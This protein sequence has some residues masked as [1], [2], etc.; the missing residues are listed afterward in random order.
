MN[1]KHAEIQDLP[2]NDVLLE[3]DQTI[4]SHHKNENK[5]D[6]DMSNVDSL[7]E[8]YDKKE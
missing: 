1:K 8:D 7:M 5:D 3:I 6:F 2:A 4:H